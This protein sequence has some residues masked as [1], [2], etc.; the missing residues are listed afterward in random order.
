MFA[1]TTA[2]LQHR[3]RGGQHALQDGEDEVA[4]TLGSGGELAWVKLHRVPVQ[5]GGEDFRLPW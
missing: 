2:D 4:I 3:A 1:G 5:R